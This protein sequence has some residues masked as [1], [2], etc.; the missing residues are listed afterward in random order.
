[1]AGGLGRKKNISKGRG[2]RIV[3]IFKRSVGATARVRVFMCFPQFL[4]L[5]GPCKFF[6][7]FCIWLE[8]YLY[9]KSLHVL[10]MEILK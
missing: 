2:C 10:F 9:R 3:F 1:L 8:V 6:S 7:S 5:S 4:F